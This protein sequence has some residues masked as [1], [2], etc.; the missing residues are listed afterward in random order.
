MSNFVF[1]FRSDKTL[2]E[3]TCLNTILS[4]LFSTV[5]IGNPFLVI[6]DFM[7]SSIVLAFD[8]CEFP[9]LSG[10]KIF[11]ISSKL[12]LTNWWVLKN[13]MNLSWNV[14]PTMKS[15]IRMTWCPK[16]INLMKVCSYLIYVNIS[17]GTVP[18]SI[19]VWKVEK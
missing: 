11:H 4:P 7:I 2:L 6:Q 3:L 16:I 12:V 10:S 14:L 13:S 1:L 18:D 15:I 9:C 19:V 5:T 17:Q 8:D